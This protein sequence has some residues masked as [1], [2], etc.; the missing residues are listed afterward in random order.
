M[1]RNLLS[2]PRVYL[3]WISAL[4]VC[5]LLQLV[6]SG[7]LPESEEARP[8]TLFAITV[9]ATGLGAVA[10]V[11]LCAMARRVNQPELGYL[12]G[13]FFVLSVLLLAHGLLT[14]G[15]IYE[16]SQGFDSSLFWSIPIA[17]VAGSP[18]LMGADEFRTKLDPYWQRW[19]FWWLAASL[20]LSGL[21]VIEGNLLPSPDP[22]SI[23]TRVV[24]IV[25]IIGCLLYSLRHVHL[26]RVSRSTVP[27]LV[28]FGFVAVGT[29]A[30]YWSS[31]TPFSNAFWIAHL[32]L[33]VGIFTGTIGALIAYKDTANVTPYI[34]AIAQVDSRHTLDLA[35]DPLLH[36]LVED[37]ERKD[38]FNR[39]HVLRTT[40]LSILIGSRLE[41]DREK[42]RQIGLAALFHDIGMTVLPDGILQ[43]P[44]PLSDK[45]YNVLK[46]HADYG[47]DMLAASQVLHPIAPIV[48]AHHE[49]ID[50][51]GYPRGLD[52]TRIPLTA[53]IV[54]ACDAYNAM[55]SSRRFRTSISVEPAIEMLE[56]HAGLYL[57][58]RVVETI[59]RYA[60]THPPTEMPTML[61]EI[62]RI[63]CDCLPEKVEFFMTDVA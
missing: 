51:T 63:G 44:G 61:D 57:D 33:V 18:S 58:R 56:R 34:E 31:G 4:A 59:V 28:A 11:M 35:V 21:L 54:A 17:L 60:R 27:M 40:E 46:R 42:I 47:A 49:R 37:L 29:S 25:S 45:E 13:F 14:P 48:R 52:G 53:R 30:F 16:Q 41:L 32:L 3:L 43:Q 39:D 23:W 15:I 22:T 10:S 9:V 55:V 2:Q 36:T 24:A 8:S 20:A 38:A 19:V 26:A 1:H 62:G 7:L 12:A 6:V 50:G 5:V